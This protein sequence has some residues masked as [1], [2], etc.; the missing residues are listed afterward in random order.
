MT[1]H[2][3]LFPMK[4]LSIILGCIFVLLL[5][6][7]AFWQYRYSLSEPQVGSLAHTVVSDSSDSVASSD[8]EAHRSRDTEVSLPTIVVSHEA[9]EYD[10]ADEL[11]TQVYIPEPYTDPLPPYPNTLINNATILGI[12]SNHNGVRD[13]YEVDVV[14]D[15]GEDNQVVQAFFAY[16]H[17]N[18][19]EMLLGPDTQL[20]DEKIQELAN[21]SITITF[22][23][24]Y[25]FR[26][27]EFYDGGM[28]DYHA[29]MKIYD[30]LKNTSKRGKSD[31]LFSQQFHG[32]ASRSQEPSDEVCQSLYTKYAKLATSNY[33]EE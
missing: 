14:D 1:T 12:D 15:Y 33:E 24:G 7:Y 10:E 19:Y 3:I 18:R 20:S 30:R 8:D 31:R 26:Q 28:G 16:A 22:C 6:F 17:Y 32:F 21:D 13:D 9:D 29:S 5:C 2:N 11:D 27:S 4:K 23:D 25:Y